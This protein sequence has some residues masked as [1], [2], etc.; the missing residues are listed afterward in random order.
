GVHAGCVRAVDKYGDYGLIGF[1]LM[2]R[3][4]GTKSLVHFAFSCRTMNMGI[5]QYVYEML[6][7]PDIDI[8][9]PVSYGLESHAA[10]DWIGMGGDT[11]RLATSGG[12]KLV[13]LGGCDLLQLASYCSS[14]RLEFV[15]RG[16]DEVT[17]RYDDP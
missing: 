1:F 10:V 2:R 3:N 9:P 7:R 14:D 16:E 13:L 4:S 12:R 11:N 5:E 17:V 6:G 15:N 8:A